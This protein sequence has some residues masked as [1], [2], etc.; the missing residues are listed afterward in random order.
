[1]IETLV[2]KRRNLPHWYVSGRTFFITF[3]IKGSLPRRVIDDIRAERDRLLGSEPD[4][5]ALNECYRKMFIKMESV[6]DVASVGAT[7]LKEP[8]IA[9]LILKG[10]EWLERKG[11]KVPAA[12][13]MPNHV[14][15]LM[16][17]DNGQTAQLAEHLGLMKGSIAREANKILG[18]N[19]SFWLSEV[20][21]HWCRSPE[22]IESAKKYIYQNPV[23]GHLVCKPEDWPWRR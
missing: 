14:H 10:F 4:P 2:F 20:F 16:R 9:A 3:R 17:N 11:W 21:D 1:M 12:V 8:R 23:K 18:R 5:E 19:G 6:L 22:K 7:W 13:V 15:C